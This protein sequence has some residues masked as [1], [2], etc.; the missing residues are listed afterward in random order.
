[1][2]SRNNQQRKKAS[3]KAVNGKDGRPIPDWKPFLSQYRDKKILRFET[4]KELEAAIEL[5]W[6]DALRNLPHTSYDGKSIIIPAEAVEY[7]TRAGLKFKATKLQSIGD[8][9]PEEIAKL[10]K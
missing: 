8:L 6:T 3:Q 10:R 1:M 4:D 5:L 2:K 7:F 9:K